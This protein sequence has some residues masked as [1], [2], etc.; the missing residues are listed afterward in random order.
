MRK[1]L[2]LSGFLLLFSSC[3][4]LNPNIMLKTGKDYKYATNPDSTKV[5]EYKIS[6]NDIL[7]FSIYSNDGFKLVDLTSLENTRIRRIEGNIDY[8]VELDG[9]VKLPVLGRKKLSGLTIREAELLLEESY[10]AFYIKPFVVMEVTNRRV[11]IF[12]GS[13]GDARVIPLRYNNMTL[14]EAL[15]QAGGIAN[16]GKAKQVKLIRQNNDKNDVY[17][18]DLSKIEGIKYGTMVLQANDIIYVESRRRYT[19]RLLQEIVP[20]VSLIST[21]FVLFTYS[22]LLTKK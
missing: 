18:I 5:S 19:S 4:W 8:L 2:Y 20:I 15:A 6:S 7:Q 11:I 16:D 9:N 13:A 12:P 14:M 22:K 10:S 17:L 3:G 21:T 1:L